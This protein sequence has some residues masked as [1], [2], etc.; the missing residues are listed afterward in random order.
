MRHGMG[1]MVQMI[2]FC[3]GGVVLAIVAIAFGFGAV[4]PFLLFGGCFLMMVM[5]MRGMGGTG[6][7]RGRGHDDQHRDTPT[8]PT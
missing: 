3:L 2:V 5:M 8:K 7:G 6:S 4:A 1:M